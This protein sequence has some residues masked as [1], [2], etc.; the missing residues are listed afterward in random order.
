MPVALNDRLP[1]PPKDAEVKNVTCEFCIVGCGYK[2]YKWPTG[3]EGTPKSNGYGV[4]FSKPQPTY[5]LWASENMFNTIKDR[6]GQSY[7][8]CVIPDQKCVVN[9]G[10]NSVRG[11]MMAKTLFTATGD[12]RDRLKEPMIYRG[13]NLIETSWEDALSLVAK[14]YKRVIDENPHDLSHKTFD[15]GGG[16]GGFENTWATGKLF[17]M[18]IGTHSASIHNRPAYNSEVH[19]SREMGVGELNSSYYD[20]SIADTVMFVGMNPY[21]CQTNLFLVHVIPNLTGATQKGKEKEYER[22]ESVASGRIIIVDPRR[23]ASIKAAEELGGN[24]K[25]VLHLQIQPGTDITLMNTLVSYIIDQGWEAKEFIQKHTENFDTMIKTNKISLAEGAKITGIP[26]EKIIQAAEWLAKPKPSGHRP[27]NAIYYEKGV[28]WGIKNYEGV[29]SIVNLALLTESIG[30]AGTGVCRGGGHQEGYTRPEFHGP[31]RSQLAV[32]DEDIVHGKYKIYSVWG[33]NPF[34]QSIMAER[35]REAVHRRA[36]IVKEVIDN[37]EGADNEIL[38]D[39]I[40]NAI[41]HK[42]GLFVVNIDIYPTQVSKAAHVILP[43]A[44]TMEMNLTSMN[45]ER[46]LRL[47]EK[48]VDA[49]GSSQPD[50]LIAAGIANALKKEYEKVGNKAMAKRFEGFDW[51]SEEDAFRDGFAGQGSD[52]A[53]Q[54]GPTGKLAS[55]KILKEAGNDGVQLPIKE[56]KGG[57][58]IGTRQ[59]YTDKKF[60]TKSGRAIFLPTPQPPLP[61]PVKKQV[62]KYEFWVNSGRINEMWQSNYH[63]SRIDFTASRWPMAIV[64][65]HPKDAAFH[66]LT[67]GDIIKL[68]NDYGSVQGIAIVTDSVQPKQLFMSFGFQNSVINDLVTEYVDPDTKIPFYKGTAA[69]LVKV[70]RSPS[71]VAGMSFKNRL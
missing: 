12:T 47:S 67:N 58:L 35:L 42:G 65:I 29:A 34:G 64:E 51:R 60:G 21:E 55:Y 43:A 46:R 33:T 57:R 62:E 2:A 37:L 66:K 70:G 61:A 11:G 69:N 1:L 9:E 23:T 7:H 16:G 4:D 5:G 10:Q 71:L 40:Y 59:L 48:V 50:C 31:H 18:A 30:R 45:G 63:T 20:T 41:T 15:H 52:M 17:H 36:N 28:I 6:N 25:N 22:G 8:V 14:V 38:A 54:G 56:I 44:T 27:R 32:I 39:A 19:S 49:P 53:S 24:P 68:Y 26:K 3:K 13:S